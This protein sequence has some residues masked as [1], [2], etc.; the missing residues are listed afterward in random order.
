MN[1][2]NKEENN[3]MGKTRDLFKKT[4]VI[5]GT[6]RTKMGTIQGRNDKDLSEVEDIKKRW[7]EY[8]EELYKQDL[9]GPNNQDT[10][11]AH[12]EPDILEC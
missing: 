4:G 10:V 8:T 6:F 5:K 2:A 12:L 3:S 1:N 9:K 7:K 11:V